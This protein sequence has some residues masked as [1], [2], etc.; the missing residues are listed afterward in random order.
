MKKGLFLVFFFA[1]LGFS[2]ITFHNTVKSQS[3]LKVLQD[4]YKDAKSKTKGAWCKS[5]GSNLDTQ[6]KDM[7]EFLVCYLGRLWT[8]IGNIPGPVKELARKAAISCA[9]ACQERGHNNAYQAL[10]GLIN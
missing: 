10:Q 8:T 7:C 6:S 9:C 2:G 4:T 1:I 5:F 3:L